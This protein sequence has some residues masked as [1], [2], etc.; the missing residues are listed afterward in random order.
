MSQTK[1]LSPEEILAKLAEIRSKI[2]YLKPAPERDLPSVAA[3]MGGH[4]AELDDFEWES[5]EMAAQSMA[6]E[7]HEA[8]EEAQAKALAKALEIYYAAEELARDPE[9]A[10][11]IPTV[12]AMRAA[13]EKDFGKPIP[14]KP[15]SAEK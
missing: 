2:P 9:H 12:E 6:D 13:Y 14:P 3:P 5:V 4:S 1:K 15:P 10:D 11:L 7:L 8:I